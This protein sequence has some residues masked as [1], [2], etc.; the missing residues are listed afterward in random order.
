MLSA[1][2]LKAVQLIAEHGCAHSARATAY[3]KKAGKLNVAGQTINR[4]HEA[5]L[6]QAAGDVWELTAAARDYLQTKA[7]EPPR[8]RSAPTYV[9]VFSAVITERRSPR[10]APRRTVF[11]R[12]DTGMPVAEVI[13]A[14]QQA[15]AQR[16]L[17]TAAGPTLPES[18]Y[19]DALPMAWKHGAHFLG[20]PASATGR[21]FRSSGDDP[22]RRIEVE[23]GQAR[24]WFGDADI[25]TCSRAWR[26]LE[27]WIGLQASECRLLSTP[28]TTGRD[29]WRRLIPR[30]AAYPVLTEEVRQLIHATSPQHRRELLPAV[31]SEL[32][33]FAYLDARLS[34]ASVAWG[35]PVGPGAWIGAERDPI[36]VD[37]LVRGRGRLR[38]RT[39]VPDS[40]AHVG[41]LPCPAG[42][43]AW[44]WPYQPRRRF[45]TWADASEVHLARTYGWPVEIIEG[46]TMAEGK[47]LNTFTDRIT[48]GIA[49]AADQVRAGDISA[50][51][52]DAVRSGLRA[53]FVGLIGGFAQRGHDVWKSAPIR[54]GEPV[55]APPGATVRRSPD[56]KTAFWL[57]HQARSD[58]S[59]A[60]PEW[61]ATIWARA[62]CR[63]LDS[64]APDRAS[65][66]GALQL[67]RAS[68]IAFA[69]DALYLDHDPGWP[70]DGQR[71]RFRRKGKALDFGPDGY[72]LRVPWPDNWSKVQILR[73]IS[74]GR[75]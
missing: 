4:L 66:L 1:T 45:E 14:A 44:E 74:E 19:L 8:A 52:G 37:Q 43:D 17:L 42:A 28:V 10:Y 38:I 48:K 9:P 53:M 41:L 71:G 31:R 55:A 58:L 27:D 57:E 54:A 22:G 11:M 6:V 13:L 3:L 56:G 16:V 29:L 69:A 26:W 2:Q 60:H 40:W 65:R 12:S 75:L 7:A 15:G 30:S 62:R 18:W 21:Y 5:G 68:V 35:M 59:F 51:V 23:V 49:A 50:P 32:T 46:F 70:D 36:E 24:T 47:P 33:G 61:A 72:A 34:Y 25:D 63:L 64:P 67:P 39:Q 20:E 73:N